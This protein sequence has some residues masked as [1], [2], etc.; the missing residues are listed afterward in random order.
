MREVCFFV[1]E[2]SETPLFCL[3]WGR[4]SSRHRPVTLVG[5]RPSKSKCPGKEFTQPPSLTIS[6][7]VSVIRHG[8]VDS[9]TY[10]NTSNRCFLPWSKNPFAQPRDIACRYEAIHP[11]P[12]GYSSLRMVCSCPANR[13]QRP[14]GVLYQH[15]KSSL[16]SYLIITDR[17]F[18]PVPGLSSLANM[19]SLQ[20][21]ELGRNSLILLRSYIARAM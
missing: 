2:C 17:V 6:A 4:R 13:F 5:S 11:W 18:M 1:N 9:T 20:T 16:A 21:H 8:V 10:I 7:N 3:F 14:C 12:P 15:S 19:R